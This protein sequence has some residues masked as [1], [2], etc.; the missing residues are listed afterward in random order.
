MKT[1][2]TDAE[3]LRQIA[4][5]NKHREA[6]DPPF[7]ADFEFARRM[8][9]QLFEA[10]ELIRQLRE[11]GSDLHAELITARHRLRLCRYANNLPGEQA[12]KRW[13]KLTS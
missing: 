4:E 6:G 8:E 7:P 9:R 5:Y 3:K 13:G 12:M 2:I 10:N 1:P 11:A